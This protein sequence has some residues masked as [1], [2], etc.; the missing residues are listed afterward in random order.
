MAG[1]GGDEKD[2][3][4][5]LLFDDLLGRFLGEKEGSLE[6]EG[7]HIFELG[8]GVVEEA[9]KGGDAGIGDGDVE[10]TVGGNGRVDHLLDRC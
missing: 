10:T 1:D 5:A 4:V 6:V 3:A 9:A 2:T 8:G 7:G